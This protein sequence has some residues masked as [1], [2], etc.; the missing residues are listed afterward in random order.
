MA[1]LSDFDAKLVILLQDDAG[2]LASGDRQ[3]FI[4]E[5]VQRF[6]QK[7]P[8]E[9]AKE[10][11]GDGSYDYALPTEWVEGFSVA[12]QVEYPAGEQEPN[13]PDDN[14]WT[15]YQGASGRKLRFLTCSP[16]TGEKILLTLT[17]PHTVTS[18]ASTVAA[19]DQ[20]AVINLAG[21]LC[22]YA[23]ARKYAQS[24]EPTIA[25]DSVNYGSKSS[26]Y[27]KRGKELEKLYNDHLAAPAK[28][29][30]LPAASVSGDWDMNAGWGADRITHP[31][32]L[33]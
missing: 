6:S 26:E 11:A 25:A 22:C 5:A 15:I 19:A 7:R 28:D 10:I 9:L 23:L 18:Q 33:R 2:I 13:Y 31:R 21:A 12:L 27:A 3:A 17:A 29:G 32:R 20:D 16:A 14:D 4:L 8:R 30:G 24:S 1:T